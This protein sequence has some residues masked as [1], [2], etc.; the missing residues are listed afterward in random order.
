MRESFGLI[1][2][3]EIIN[4][5]FV[6]KSSVFSVICTLTGLNYFTHFPTFLPR[7]VS[8][9]Q[10]FHYIV[11]LHLLSEP[12]TQQERTTLLKE[13][14]VMKVL[15]PHPNIIHLL[16]CCTESGKTQRKVPS[17]SRSASDQCKSSPYVFGKISGQLIN[18]FHHLKPASDYQLIRRVR[19]SRRCR[20]S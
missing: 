7:F 16:G 12:H 8:P 10:S 1:C 20:G 4:S 17:C 3:S 5:I 13:L 18:V 11:P 9:R 14:R 15:Q 6:K 19:L 2:F